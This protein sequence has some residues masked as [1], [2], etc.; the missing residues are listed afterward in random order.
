MPPMLRKIYRPGKPVLWDV[1]EKE[2][3]DEIIFRTTKLRNR[4]ILE[5][6]ARGGMRVGEVLKL[7]PNDVNDQKLTIQ[8]PKSGKDSEVVFIPRKVVDRLRAYVKDRAV[9]ADHGVLHPFEPHKIGVAGR[10]VFRAVG[11]D[12]NRVTHLI[13][14]PRIEIT[15]SGRGTVL[16]NDLRRI[17]GS[18]NASQ[19]TKRPVDEIKGPV[20]RVPSPSLIGG[21]E[22]LLEVLSGPS[23][24][25]KG[26]FVMPS[27]KPVH[28]LGMPCDC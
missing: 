12:V 25:T 3:V 18:V 16:P 22:Q 1:V 10:Q 28:T 9:Q 19:P 8:N 15:R 11:R 4:L 23:R 26:F 13:H 2:T 14:R 7:T 5:L 6:M 17:T 27:S 20:E 21:T 24:F